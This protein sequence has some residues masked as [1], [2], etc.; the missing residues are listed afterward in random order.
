MIERTKKAA[1]LFGILDLL[2]PL[3]QYIYCETVVVTN[4]PPGEPIKHPKF[5]GSQEII[6]L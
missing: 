3:V 6:S 2:P 5:K 1:F 4:V